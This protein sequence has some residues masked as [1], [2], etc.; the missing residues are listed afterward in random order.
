MFIWMPSCAAGPERA[1]DWPRTI[2]V[3]V[4]PGVG[5]CASAAHEKANAAASADRRSACRTMLHLEVESLRTPPGVGPAR[6]GAL[7][8]NAGSVPKFAARRRDARPAA[9][10]SS[11]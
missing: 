8:S 7:R 9:P 6:R 4:T 3:G 1:A 5:A 10:L 2:V 11:A